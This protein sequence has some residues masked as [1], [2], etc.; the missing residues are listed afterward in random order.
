LAGAGFPLIPCLWAACGKDPGYTPQMILE[1]MAMHSHYSALEFEEL[2]FDGEIIS[3]GDC[4]KIFIKT[5]E[6]ASKAFST[7]PNEDA[8]VLY[9]NRDSQLAVIPS[10]SDFSNNT[11]IKNCGGLFGVIL[12]SE[13][14]EMASSYSLAP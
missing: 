13:D 8:G 6:N 4:K 5:L 12:L 14:S 3:P 10:E 9:I 2:K 1:H 11:V 7:F